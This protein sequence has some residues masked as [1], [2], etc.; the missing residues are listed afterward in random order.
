MTD[1]IS[2]TVAPS[3]PPSRAIDQAVTAGTSQDLATVGR[4]ITKS[5]GFVFNVRTKPRSPVVLL[6]GI[7]FY[8]DTTEYVN[9]EVWTRP[10]SFADHRGTYD[11]WSLIASGKT[12]GLGV[13]T[14]TPVPSE[15]LTPV[16]IP[17]DNGTRAFYIT[18]DS[19]HLIYKAFDDADIGES[20][21]KVRVLF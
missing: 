14:F 15:L 16:G 4:D 8:V 13:G 7:D 5:Y 18:L 21:T 1:D 19:N 3:T 12:R 10:G 6:T 17:G 9:F 20:D 2:A 11:G